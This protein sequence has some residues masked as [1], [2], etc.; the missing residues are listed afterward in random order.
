MKTTAE[1]VKAWSGLAQFKKAVL[2]SPWVL[3]NE[4]LEML[5]QEVATEKDDLRKAEVAHEE[6]L[7]RHKERKKEKE[8]TLRKRE[9]KRETRRR[10]EE[11]L[12]NAGAL[13]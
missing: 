4:E 7:K 9:V 5:Q 11:V 13:I 10:N 2:L 3:T 8:E 1:E 6:H 12:L